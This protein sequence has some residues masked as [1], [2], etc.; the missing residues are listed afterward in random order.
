MLKDFAKRPRGG[1]VDFLSVPL[2]NL[3]DRKGY[4]FSLEQLAGI[5]YRIVK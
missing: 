5:N 1:G 3:F 4:L 2:Q